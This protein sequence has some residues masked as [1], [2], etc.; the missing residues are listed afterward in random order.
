MVVENEEFDRKSLR[1]VQGKQAA[2]TEVAVDCVAFAN[3]A[4][5]RLLIG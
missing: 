4:G 1:K 5:G 2:W 3:S